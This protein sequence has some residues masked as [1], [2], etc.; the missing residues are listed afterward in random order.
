MSQYRMSVKG[1]SYAQDRIVLTQSTQVWADGLGNPT[2]NTLPR[3][4]VERLSDLVAKLQRDVD[5]D[6]EERG[7]SPYR[8]WLDT[9][10][11]PV[12]PDGKRIALERITSVYRDAAHVLV[13][14]ASFAAFKSKVVEPPELLFRAGSCSAWMRRLWTLQEGILARSLYYQFADCA[15][16]GKVLLS[17]LPEAECKDIRYRCLRIDL[18]VQL[19]PLE[20]VDAFPSNVKPESPDHMPNSTLEHQIGLL[21]LQHAIEFRS[22]SVPR[23]EPICIAT[24]MGLD[25]SRIASENGEN[26]TQRRMATVWEML[27]ERL[28]G[29]PPR[30]IFYVNNGL[31]IAGF[32]WAPKS[33]LAADVQQLSTGGDTS[34]PYAERPFIDSV[35]DSGDRTVR[36]F[37][38]SGNRLA[39][40][41]SEGD[42]RGLRGSYPGFSVHARPYPGVATAPEHCRLHPWDGDLAR[43]SSLLRLKE[44]ETGRWFEISVSNITRASG[45]WADEK[46]DIS[47]AICE[48]I[49]TGRCA[50]IRQ[51]AETVLWFDGTPKP[52]N[53]LI[54]LLEQEDGTEFV[55]RKK[56]IVGLHELTEVDV[57]VT[58]MIT[59]IAEVLAGRPGLADRLGGSKFQ[60]ERCRGGPEDDCVELHTT[61]YIRTCT[62]YVCLY[63][64][65]L[66]PGTVPRCSTLG[67]IVVGSKSTSTQY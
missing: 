14:D 48:A 41:V 46:S 6:W 20:D 23:D 18:R 21:E 5:P 57:T 3:C 29:I 13:L 34:N 27:A 9:L 44:E 17:K 7:G 2:A 63:Y 22:V 16:M 37:C 4:Q 35:L 59:E 38:K 56:C 42:R 60:V 45:T 49:Q 11:Y 39:Q 10:C 40:L 32:R 52:E 55:V 54:V 43:G 31:E 25:I 61:D 58:E 15:V 8:I 24:I 67:L 62:E 12:E 50:I 36:F 33:L 30:I 51:T 47:L 53:S 28:G 66:E 19:G 26:A 1:W 65:V 64:L